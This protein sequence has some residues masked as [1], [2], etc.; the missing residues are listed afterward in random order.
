[1]LLSIL[2]LGMLAQ[3]CGPEHGY[4]ELYYPDWGE[5][6][7]INKECR[8]QA[9]ENELWYQV[10]KGFVCCA[11]DDMEYVFYLEYQ[12]VRCMWYCISYG[13]EE[14]IYVSLQFVSAYEGESWSLQSEYTN[15][16]ICWYDVIDLS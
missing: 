16:G 11:P 13:K 2:C 4:D 9:G 12:L 6:S 7:R 8:Q 10:D 1:M 3:S 14:D 15:V 5:L